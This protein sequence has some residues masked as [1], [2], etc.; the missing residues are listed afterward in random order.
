MKSSKVQLRELYL[1]DAKTMARLAD[2]KNIWDNVRDRFPH[3]Y[4]EKDAS[5]F[6]EGQREDEDEKVFAIELD[7]E[8]CGCIGLIFQKDVYRKSAEIGYWVGENF[9][10][11]NV[12][13]EALSQLIEYAFKNLELNR[14]YAGVFEYNRSSMRV[15]EK[16]GFQ[17]EGLFKKA[18]F[19]N[20]K[21]WDEY[22]YALVYDH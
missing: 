8:F 2:N 13:T 12:A 11:K 15:L 1:S 14:L 18:V 10:G 17:R 3:P 20:G 22:R 9:W 21:F 19:K 4:T 16:N 7:G 6:I 5:V